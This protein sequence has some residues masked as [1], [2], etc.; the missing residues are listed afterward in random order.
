MFIIKK[1]TTTVALKTRSVQWKIYT[2]PR[3][4]SKKKKNKTNRFCCF[5][6]GAIE[7]NYDS[8][9]QSINLKNKKTYWNNHYKYIHRYE[10]ICWFLVPC[11][12][13]KS[14]LQTANYFEVIRNYNNYNDLYLQLIKLKRFS[15]TSYFKL[16]CSSS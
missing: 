3:K 14:I 2:T 6:R 16:F 13:F 4:F 12:H 1:I 11:K 8:C 10:N 15:M 5:N 9:N 7:P